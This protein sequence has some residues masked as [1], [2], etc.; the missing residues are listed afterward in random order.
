MAKNARQPTRLKL[1]REVFEIEE[2]TLSLSKKAVAAGASFRSGSDLTPKPDAGH[3]GAG[4]IQW[5]RQDGQ[6][7]RSL[8]NASREAIPMSE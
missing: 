6:S 2:A 5:R 7:K 1:I 3:K 4:R 8:I